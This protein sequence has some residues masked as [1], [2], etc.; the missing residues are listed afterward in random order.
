M[1]L[2]ACSG[3]CK[4]Y[5]MLC[6]AAGVKCRHVNANQWTHQW[7]EV[8]INGEWRIVDTQ[9]GWIELPDDDS[10]LTK[11]F[12]ITRMGPIYLKTKVYDFGIEKFKLYI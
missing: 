12:D 7:N 2:S 9:G 3:H 10:L 8:Y 11:A 5:K 4:A 1:H 6:D